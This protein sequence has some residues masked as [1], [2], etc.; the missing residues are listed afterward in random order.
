M[1]VHRD[2]RGH[3]LG[4]AVTLAGAAALRELGSSS[5]DVCTMSANVGG[6]AAYESAGFVR[7]PE[8]LDRK[9]PT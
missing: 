8:R 4:R 5:A 3:G 9:R 1:G 7:L 2:H 6:I